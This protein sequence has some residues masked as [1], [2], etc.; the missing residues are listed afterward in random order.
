MNLA[1]ID[2]ATAV[3]DVIALAALATSIVSIRRSN[4]AESLQ[5]KVAELDAK[6]KAYELADAEEGRKACVEARVISV[7]KSRRL[8][9]CNVGK[10]P[11]REVDF[12]VL[13]EDR[14]GLVMR[15]HVP[16]PELEYQKSFD[17]VLIS[18]LGLSP[19]FDVE[20]SWVD[21]EGSRQAKISHISL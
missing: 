8:R 6:L 15:D 7:G 11:A 3:G 18:H 2:I 20:V 5:A 13:D 9:I 4:K 10:E 12:K 1:S 21:A 14:V 19:V 16:F 17:E